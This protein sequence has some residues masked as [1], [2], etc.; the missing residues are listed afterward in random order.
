MGLKTRAGE[1][2]GAALVA[3]LVA[4]CSDDE[5]T[6]KQEA[7]TN[8][9]EQVVEYIWT[10]GEPENFSDHR[11][12]VRESTLP[13]GVVR[14]D[15]RW[16]ECE[17]GCLED[18][19]NIEPQ[20]VEDA[21]D[22]L[23]ESHRIVTDPSKIPE[24]EGVEVTPMK[25][26]YNVVIRDPKQPDQKALEFSILSP[27][28]LSGG[29]DTNN[30]RCGLNLNTD[31]EG[32]ASTEFIT[33]TD[34]G[35]TGSPEGI[36]REVVYVGG[37]NQKKVIREDYNDSTTLTF[38]RSREELETLYRKTLIQIGVLQKVPNKQVSEINPNQNPIPSLEPHRL[39]ENGFLKQRYA[40][41]VLGL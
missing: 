19:C 35:C 12:R 39:T 25:N 8:S 10:C 16:E 21:P 36:I 38:G 5:A 17:D 27:Y 34:K 18:M 33:Y 20:P 15:D 4:A 2:A 24:K 40:P 29:L 37:E 14:I 13:N 7:T 26:G 32:T 30:S 28:N 6:P 31:I 3:I 9:S 41:R 1:A 23:P 11:I 22:T